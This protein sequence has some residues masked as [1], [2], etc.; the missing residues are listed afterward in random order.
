MTWDIAGKTCLITGANTGIGRVTARVLAERG[1]H[2]VLTCR[3]AEKARP[4][5][6]EIERVAGKGRA[7]FLPL[8]LSSLA[9]VRECAEAFLALDLP[10]EVLIL[11]A[12]LAG[13]KGLT[14]DGFEMTFGVNHLAHF[15]LTKLLLDKL[16]ASAPARVVVVA[17]KAH[18]KTSHLDLD[19]FTKK[20][21]GLSGFDAYIQSKLANVLFSA[22]LARR[23][24]GTG[25]T[26]YALHPGVIKSD[27]WRKIPQPFRA[28]FTRHMKTV[29]EGAQTTLYC[30]CEPSL[31][32]STGR[33]YA[34]C[35]E[36]EPS[37]TAKDPALA[38]L[39]WEKSEAWV[40]EKSAV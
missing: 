17:S 2:V 10:L 24:E 18:L 6:D 40:A 35:R 8:E 12:G 38:R 29:E 15:L 26:T 33:Y 22:E 20:T 34:A 39:L 32:E 25:V 3:T 16:K 21:T 37:E 1:A 4:V 5:L 11:N 30:A 28:F 19:S 36:V 27:V 23:L 14:Q 7:Q 31:S 13:H 9:S